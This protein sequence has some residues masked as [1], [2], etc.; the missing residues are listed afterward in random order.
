[1]KTQEYESPE[2]QIA[3]LIRQHTREAYIKK[4]RKIGVVIKEENG[5]RQV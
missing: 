3:K 4:L 2:E 5:N 1:M